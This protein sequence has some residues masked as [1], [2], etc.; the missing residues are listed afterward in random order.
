[1]AEVEAYLNQTCQ[2]SG[3]DGLQFLAV[4]NGHNNAQNLHVYCRPDKAAR[5]HYKVTSVPIPDR[6]PDK[7][8][9]PFL[10]DP[11]VRIGPF[12]FGNDGEPDAVLIVQIV[13]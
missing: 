1:M 11:T 9:K 12:Y 6:N 5:V 10:G 2:T 13:K 8:V 7:A 4:Q 3:L